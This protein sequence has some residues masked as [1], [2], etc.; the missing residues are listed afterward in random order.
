[1]KIEVEIGTIEVDALPEGVTVEALRTAISGALTKRISTE[2]I[3]GI[4]PSRTA[5][6]PEVPDTPVAA[7]GAKIAAGI[8]GGLNR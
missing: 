6:R 7:L 3:A 8:H 1:M 4:A 2:G 5:P